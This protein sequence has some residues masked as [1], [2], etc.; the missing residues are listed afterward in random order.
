MGKK[1]MKNR[2]KFTI[3]AMVN[4]IWYTIT[5]LVLSG[6]E[7]SVPDSLTVAWFAA[8][9][10]ELAILFGLKLKSGGE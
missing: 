4:I 8:W 1:K 9:T 5:V 3:A 7:K 10:A 2:T 6:F